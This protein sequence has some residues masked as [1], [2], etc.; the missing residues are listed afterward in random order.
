MAK[1]K[2]GKDY[3]GMGRIV[4]I[5]FA[6]IPVTS[7]LFG[8]ITRFQEKKYVAG[9]LRLLLGWNIIW[10]IDFILVLFTGKILRII[11]A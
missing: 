3:F 2:K 1:S 10:V 8:F 9:I 4:S 5:I 11:N 6:L 7:W